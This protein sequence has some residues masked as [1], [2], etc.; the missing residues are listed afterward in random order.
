MTMREMEKEDKQVTRPDEEI[1]TPPIHIPTVPNGSGEEIL[2]A[3]AD[4]RDQQAG[5][6]DQVHG[7]GQV[8][9]DTIAF[10]QLENV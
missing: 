2:P 4:T 10:L 6:D 3:Q 9:S 8:E 5:R 1:S 7:E